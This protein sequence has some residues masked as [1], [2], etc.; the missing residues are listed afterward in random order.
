MDGWQLLWHGFNLCMPP[1]AWAAL[2][3]ALCKWIWRRELAAVSWR[4][5]AA[6]CGAAAQAV[7]LA[8]L[9]FTGRDGAMATYGAVL[10]ALALTTWALAFA[11]GHRRGR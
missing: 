4:R 6:W 1:L 5:L 7:Y 2:H 8:G 9:W 11:P 10:L 3:A